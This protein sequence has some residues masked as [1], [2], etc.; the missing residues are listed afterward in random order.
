MRTLQF[1]VATLLCPLTVWYAVGVAMR[2]ILYDAGILKSV[3]TPIPSIGIGNLRMGGTGKTPHTEHL[4]NL[5]SD[6][7]IAL[8]SRGYRRK[9]HGFQL[10]AAN[11]DAATLGDEPAMMADKYPG[12]TVAVCE[13][14]S[15]GLRRLAQMQQLPE[16][17]LLDDVYQHRHVKPTVTLLLT[18]YRDLF[19]D[20][21]ILP[22]GNLR[23]F[24]SGHRRA[25]IVVVTKCPP[26]LSPSKRNECRSRL[27][28][29]DRQHLFFSSIRY[30][31]PLPHFHTRP[32]QPV[33][34][35]LLVTGIANPN[36]LKHHLEKLCTVR[37][38]AF[39]DHHRFS[40]GDCQRIQ[41]VYDAIKEPQ[42]AVVTTEKDKLRMTVPDIKEMLQS[43]PLYYIPI[44][45]SFFDGDAFE[46]TIKKFV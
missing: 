32:W 27:M 45:I 10:A 28:L 6:R 46:Q 20:D 34:E 29:D 41:A 31:P 23:E 3:P 36:P 11:A 9:T 30:L 42:K 21:H 1:I 15:E 19:C 18:E 4:V 33:K 5:F 22:F 2:N 16:L 44:E 40:T 37:L 25:D 12:L 24:R 14:R 43:L 8:L 13:D 7:R 38:L 17:V 35:V 39:P 26:A